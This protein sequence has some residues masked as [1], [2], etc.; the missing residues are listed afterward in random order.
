MGKK[1]DIDSAFCFCSK[2]TCAKCIVY[3]LEICEPLSIRRSV[4]RQSLLSQAKLFPNLFC[5]QKQFFTSVGCTHTKTLQQYFLR[6]ST[7]T[8]YG[9]IHVHVFHEKKNETHVKGV[10]SKVHGH[11]HM[12]NCCGTT[13]KITASQN[14]KTCLGFFLAHSHYTTTVSYLKFIVTITTTKPTTAF[15][16]I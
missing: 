11:T 5:R 9:A 7:K 6:W 13:F 1:I 14:P 4:N 10:P 2:N 12:S 16:L 3:A 15:R 8:A